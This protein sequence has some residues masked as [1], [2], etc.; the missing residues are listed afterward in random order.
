MSQQDM[1]VQSE[2]I[3]FSKKR[4]KVL[5]SAFACQPGKGSEEGTGWR[6]VEHMS[7]FHEVW[8]FVA[9]KFREPIE[10]YL[11]SHPMPNVHWVFYDLPKWMF[12]KDRL[13]AKHLRIYYYLWQIW[14]YGAAKSLHQQVNFD[15]SHHLTYGSYWRPSFL[16]RL[17]VPFLWG[18]VGGAQSIPQ[19][20]NAVVPR[21]ARIFNRLKI[22]V[23][24]FATHF[25]PFVR[26]TARNA[27]IAVPNTPKGVQRMTQLGVKNIHMM[28]QIALPPIDIERLDQLPIRENPSPFRVISLGR[29]IGWK[30][31]HIGLMA[32][33]RFSKQY[34]DSEYWHVGEGPLENYLETLARSLG[35]ADKFKI[36]RGRNRLEAFECLGQSDVLLFPGLYDEP[37]WVV[38][39][40]MAAGRPVIFLQ[41]MPSTPGSEQTGIKPRTDTPEHA[42][43]DMAAGMLKLATDPELRLKMGEAGKQHIHQYYNANNWFAEMEQLYH[44]MVQ[45]NSHHH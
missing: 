42:I 10:K 43:E 13:L 24:G 11:E 39:E 5:I 45:Q 40:A 28:P 15:V 3:E 18:P 41:G 16:A 8:V 31:I 19:Q 26:R 20:F 7:Q 9:P 36:M 34:P 30:G 12:F 1:A 17:T 37:G 27:T 33:A 29:L 23:E 21:N 2:N 22:L 44:Q 4:L 32:F 38:L 6:G 35:V 25:D 14:A